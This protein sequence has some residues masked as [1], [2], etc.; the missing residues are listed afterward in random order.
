MTESLD[1]MTPACCGETSSTRASKDSALRTRKIRSINETHPDHS[2]QLK[3]LNRVI[4]QLEGIK[5]M[6]AQRRY[7]PDIL[8][9]TRAAHSALKA[10]EIAIL[11]SHLRHCVTEAMSSSNSRAAMNKVRELVK[12]IGR[13]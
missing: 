2:A 8:I 1:E 10:A 11:E 6:I 13:F 9:Q 12:V 5:R 7:C 3:R 4:G